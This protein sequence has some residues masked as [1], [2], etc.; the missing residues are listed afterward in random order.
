M[1]RTKKALQMYRKMGVIDTPEGGQWYIPPKLFHKGINNQ[2]LWELPE[3][4]R[5][6]LLLYI[7]KY[8]A[9]A[10]KKIEGTINKLRNRGSGFSLF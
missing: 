9:A 3:A 2:T 10:D 4:Q 7:R 6:Q 5:D 8:N 1:D